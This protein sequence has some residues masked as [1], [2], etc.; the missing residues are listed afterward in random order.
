MGMSDERRLATDNRRPTT[1]DRR[2]IFA[3]DA[4]SVVGRRWSA[5][6]LRI[7]E[8]V[9]HGFAPANRH[10]VG[11]AVEREL[12]RLLAEQALPSRIGHS[13]DLASLDGGSIELP[14]GTPAET[15]GVRIAQAIYRCC[16]GKVDQ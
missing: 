7:D 5:V 15:I 4:A 12:A 6:E 11:A 13:A 3:D 16:T 2:P 8:L 1:D 10:H 9:L 14:A